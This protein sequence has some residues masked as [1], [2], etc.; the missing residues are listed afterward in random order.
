MD[1]HSLNIKTE[2][3]YLSDKKQLDNLVANKDKKNTYV[4]CAFDNLGSQLLQIVREIND[5][6]TTYI[7]GYNRKLVFATIVSNSFLEDYEEEV[8][9]YDVIKDN[10]GMGFLGDLTALL[11][12]RLWLQKMLSKLDYGWD[13]LE[14]SLFD[15]ESSIFSHYLTNKKLNIN[16]KTFFFKFVLDSHLN[17]LYSQYLLSGNEDN[18]EEIKAI[19]ENFNLDIEEINTTVDEFRS[20]RDSLHIAYSGKDMNI[21]HFYNEIMPNIIMSSKLAQNLDNCLKKVESETVS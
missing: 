2:S 3:N 18:I 10:S 15:N 8:K 4:F 21:K 7:A 9:D 12:L 5:I 20:K 1:N 13:Y 14:Y 19:S 16:D 6:Y 11:M 17:N